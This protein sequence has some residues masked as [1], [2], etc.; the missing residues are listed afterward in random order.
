MRRLNTLHY[1]ELVVMIPK[2]SF[3][4]VMITKEK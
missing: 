2:R 3:T 4:F 1:A